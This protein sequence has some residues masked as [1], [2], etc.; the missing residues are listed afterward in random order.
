MKI[1][2][3]IWTLFLWFFM[4]KP[5][6]SQPIL[7]VSSDSSKVGELARVLINLENVKTE[8]AYSSMTLWFYYDSTLIDLERASFSNSFIPTYSKPSFTEAFNASIPEGPFK[9]GNI[10]FYRAEKI[11]A[12]GKIA[13]LTFFLKKVGSAKIYF[14]YAELGSYQFPLENIIVEPIHI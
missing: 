7:K 12:E 9:K 4:L 5:L 11:T 6:Y 10:G 8:D 3:I 14:E 2:P 13:E 1:K